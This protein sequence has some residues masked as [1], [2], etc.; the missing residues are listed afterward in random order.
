LRPLKL[1]ELSW[2]VSDDSYKRQPRTSAARTRRV[3]RRFRRTTRL[4][5][6]FASRV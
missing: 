3:V 1:V 5:G 6:V 2:D 4:V